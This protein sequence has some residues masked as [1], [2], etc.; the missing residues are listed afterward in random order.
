MAMTLLSE[1][2]HGT[3]SGRVHPHNGYYAGDFSAT[4]Q[5]VSPWSL[6]ASYRPRLR[7]PTASPNPSPSATSLVGTHPLSRRPDLAP[8]RPVPYNTSE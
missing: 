8:P 7:P 5:P 2:E 1:E 3:C 6:Y 4:R